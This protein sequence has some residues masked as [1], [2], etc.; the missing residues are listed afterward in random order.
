MYKILCSSHKMYRSLHTNWQCDL[1]SRYIVGSLAVLL[2][3]YTVPG[4]FTENRCKEKIVQPFFFSFSHCPSTPLPPPPT[5]FSASFL[6]LFVFFFFLFK[7]IAVP[8]LVKGLH[9]SRLYHDILTHGLIIRNTTR[10]SECPFILFV[11]SLYHHFQG[12]TSLSVLT[13]TFLFS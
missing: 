9:W 13:A 1:A 7:T 12:M 6:Y 8:S 11:Y 10:L 2:N 3:C 5:H 4:G